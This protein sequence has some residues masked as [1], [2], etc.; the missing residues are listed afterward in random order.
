ME[1][2]IRK[3]ICVFVC[4]RLGHFA[5]LQKLALQCKSTII[6]F[7]YLKNNKS[8]DSAQAGTL[9]AKASLASG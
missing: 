7:S 9:G 2:K 1:D 5:V 3:G 6:K 8:G 4:E